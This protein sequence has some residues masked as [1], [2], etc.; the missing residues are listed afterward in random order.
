LSSRIAGVPRAGFVVALGLVTVA[1]GIAM[2]AAFDD[3]W[4]VA[5]LV[6]VG[7]FTMFVSFHVG[8]V[9][10]GERSGRGAAGGETREEK[11]K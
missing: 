9:L 3:G 10:V 7:A 5:I 11:K 2:V 1:A 8:R 6:A 4:L